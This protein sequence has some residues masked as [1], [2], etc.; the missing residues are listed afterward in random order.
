MGSFLIVHAVFVV[1]VILI[2][3]FSR[4]CISYRSGDE[5]ERESQQNTTFVW[6][7]ICSILPIINII[8]LG[9]YIM[10]LIIAYGSYRIRL[11]GLSEKFHKKL[12]N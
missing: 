1:L 3:L 7:L 2:A 11:P 12:F 4:T 9:M 6:G 5:S 10:N 8:V